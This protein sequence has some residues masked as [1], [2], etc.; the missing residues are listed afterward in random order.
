MTDGNNNFV[1]LPY[2]VTGQAS[3]VFTA[4]G[5]GGAAFCF[6]GVALSS[7]PLGSAEAQVAQVA[8]TPT[9]YTVTISTSLGDLV[10]GTML[11][12]T[13]YW[14]SSPEGRSAWAR[15]RRWGRGRCAWAR[16]A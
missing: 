15:A 12:D 6:Y 8:I 7:G 4:A 9:D 16:P 10:T 3:L 11:P 1:A 2:P 14:L 13:T 5:C